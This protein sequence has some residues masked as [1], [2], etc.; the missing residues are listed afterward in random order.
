MN[1]KSGV[2]FS[3]IEN[4]N[5]IFFHDNVWNCYGLNFGGI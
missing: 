4:P 3:C 1:Y 2:N 5:D